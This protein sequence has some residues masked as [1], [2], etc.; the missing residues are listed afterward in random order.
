VHTYATVAVAWG[1]VVA[2]NGYR[3]ELGLPGSNQSGFAGRQA[4]Y[5]LMAYPKKVPSQRQS[6]LISVYPGY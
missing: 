2:Y 3:P 4:T 1:E 5:P 6:M